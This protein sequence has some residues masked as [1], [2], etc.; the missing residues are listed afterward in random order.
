[1]G[2]ADNFRDRAAAAA[3]ARQ[4]ALER[5][6]AKPAPDDPQV[7]KRN[8]ERQAINEAREA[9]AALRAVEREAEKVR[10]SAGAAI[11][12]AEQGMKVLENLAKRANGI[13]AAAEKSVGDAAHDIERKAAR[14]KRY[15]ARKNRK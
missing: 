9:R 6:R 8:A 15:A 3:K 4:A 1:M 7:L 5:F 2:F 13:T 11:R 10:D 12:E 14:D